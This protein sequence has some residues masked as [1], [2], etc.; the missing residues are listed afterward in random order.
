MILLCPEFLSSVLQLE[1]NQE[2][3][4][5]CESSEHLGHKSAAKTHRV[6]RDQVPPR[7]RGN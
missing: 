4:N 5:Y 1:A 7:N 6:R 3:N 2:V